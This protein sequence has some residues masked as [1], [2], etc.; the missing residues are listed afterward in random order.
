MTEGFSSHPAS[1]MRAL[2]AQMLSVLPISTP[3]IASEIFCQPLIAM[4][5]FSIKFGWGYSEK[6]LRMYKHAL[7]PV[8]VYW[9]NNCQWTGK[10]GNGGN[11]LIEP[12][13][14][15]TVGVIT[16]VACGVTADALHQFYLS[17]LNLKSNDMSSSHLFSHNSNVV[18]VYYRVGKKIGEGS[19]G[20]IFEG[21]NL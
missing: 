12:L 10:G 17:I 21:T 14:K 19:F 20:V 4:A 18:G 8:M 1:C 2:Q 5:N 15:W 3:I 9:L 11:P 7:I 16:T 13:R 6:T